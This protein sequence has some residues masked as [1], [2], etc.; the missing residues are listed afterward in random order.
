MDNDGTPEIIIGDG[1]WGTVHVHD[2][3]TQ[4]EKWHANNPEHGVTDVAVGDVDNDGVADLLWGAGW[5]SSGSDYLYVAE[6]TGTH[7]IKWRSIDLEGP[8]LGPVIGDLDGDG[9]LELVI[10]SFFSESAYGSGR[11]LVFDLATGALRGISDPVVSNF[12]WTGVHDLKLRDL[13][14]DGHM[15]I[16]IGADYLYDGAIEIYGF[17]SN[18]AFSLKWENTTRP[19]GSPFNFVD[20][21]D[22]DGNGIPEIIA[23]NTVAHTGSEG[24][25][26]YIY[27]YPSGSNPSRSVNL[28]SGFSA[29]TGMIVQDLDGNG[30]REIAALVSNGDLYTFD[31]PTRQLR[32]LVQNTGATLLSSRPNPS[33]LITADSAGLAHFLKYNTNGYTEILTPQLGNSALDT[34][35]VGSDGFLWSS[36]SGVLKLRLSPSYNTVAWQSPSM[37]YFGPTIATD[38]RNGERH[39][40]GSAAQGVFG[41]SYTL[42]APTLLSAVSRKTHGGAGAFDIPLPLIGSTGVECRSSNG[43]HTIVLTLNE[44]PASG[45]ASITAGSGAVQGEPSFSGNLAFV[46]LTG[47]GNAQRVTINLANFA[48]TGGSA[49]PSTSLTFGVL[50]G[51]ANGNQLVNA[52][53]IAQTKS[54]SGQ[55]L[56]ATNFR[57][58]VNCNGTVNSADVS[59]VK[60]HSGSGL[61]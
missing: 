58:D 49:L 45:H 25:Y 27:N 50:E 5:T 38:V 55:V 33:T 53:D 44:P 26:V 47:V 32:S 51:D 39:V 24:V 46:T 23:G 30:T 57:S 17:N 21:A 43:T 3:N 11:I 19:S 37:G 10:C 8:F 18:N 60:A 13:E 2:L 34:V 35:N 6:T 1:Q 7:D 29:V 52:S 40:F 15:E 22:L 28:A 4:T 16:V 54:R 41:F 48:A 61:P 9:Q 42:P 56:D 20:V 36:A 31:G 14:G 12:A 59:S